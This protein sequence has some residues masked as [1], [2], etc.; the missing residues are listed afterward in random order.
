MKVFLLVSEGFEECYTDVAVY[1]DY[2]SAYTEFCKHRDAEDEIMDQGA[3]YFCVQD[4]DFDDMVGW[5][6]SI[7]EKEIQGDLREYDKPKR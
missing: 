7:L 4:S 3:D 6:M 1:A 2:A 5:Q